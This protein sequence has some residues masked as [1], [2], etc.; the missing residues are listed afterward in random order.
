MPLFEMKSFMK[1]CKGKL[2]G[3]T[4]LEILVSIAIFAAI[5]SVLYPSYTATFRNI[6]YTES[7]AE[8]YRMARVAMERITRDIRAA[9]IPSWVNEKE[10]EDEWIQETGFLG[11]DEHINGRDADSLRFFCHEHLTFREDD[12]P[13]NAFISYYIKESRNGN[14]TLYR[15]DTHEFANPPEEGTGGLIL[16]EGLHSLQFIYFDENGE[17]YDN[18]D[19]SSDRLKNRLP[20][21]ASI[22]LE[23]T[24]GADA[25]SVIKFMTS[26]SLP[27]ARNRYEKAS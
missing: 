13:G 8:I 1:S 18:W 2:N 25:E 19:S 9:Y 16:C 6:E 22:K 14:F 27:M 4:L 24:H 11:E 7:E 12:M 20:V 23:F 10:D 3:F 26:V 15:S 21:M 5:I 17:S